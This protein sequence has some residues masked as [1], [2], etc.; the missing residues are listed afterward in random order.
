MAFRQ[1]S[2]QRVIEE[3]RA[4]AASHPTRKIS[5][6]DNIMPHAYFKTLLPRL[7]AELPR[8]EIFYE[9]KAN[10]SLSNLLALKAAGITRVQPGIEALS[11]GLLKRMKKGVLARQ[12]LMLLRDARAAGVKLSWNLLWGF[13]G[14]DVEEY[15]EISR[16]LPLLHHLQPPESLSHISIDRF[17]PYFTRPSEFGI[18]NLRPMAAY[19]HCLPRTADVERIACHFIGDY[20]CGSHQRLDVICRLWRQL[21]S[22]RAAWEPGGAE[23]PEDLRILQ[24]QGSCLVVDTRRV[25]GRK[26]TLVVEPDEALGLLTSRPYSGDGREAR[27]VNQKLAVIVDGWFVPLA[28]PDPELL[29]EMASANNECNAT[30]ETTLVRL[31]VARPSNQQT[32]GGRNSLWAPPKGFLP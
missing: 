9:V 5:M 28:V 6:T 29:M 22:W 19:Y 7:A 14:D 21:K 25:T 32:P 24:R 16:I 12:N 23:P 13:P 20:N 1:K 2:P 31:D 8:L 27:A 30:S 3:L 26:R 10:L 4:L 15:R 17:S 11:S 18:S